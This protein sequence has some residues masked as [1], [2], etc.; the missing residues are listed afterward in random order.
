MQNIE[1]TNLLSKTLDTY[2]N[3]YRSNKMLLIIVVSIDSQNYNMWK[4]SNMIFYLDF[5]NVITYDYVE[6]FDI[7]IAHQSNLYS[8]IYNDSQFTSFFT[9]VA[10]KYYI[11]AEISIIMINLDMSFYD[12]VFQHTNNIRKSFHDVDENFFEKEIWD[13]KALFQSNAIEQINQQV[14]ISYNWNE[15]KR[16]IIS[17]D[18]ITI[19]NMK[20]DYIKK[21]NLE[22]DMFWELSE[23]EQKKNNLIDNGSISIL[24]IFCEINVKT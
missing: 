17:Y 22:S 4:L 6:Y 2:I 9:N 20:V 5:V 3:Q 10:I 11:N 14:R 18:T 16:L 7:V 24:N 23:N 13:H 1:Y 12:C 15:K 19:F 8:S 21:N